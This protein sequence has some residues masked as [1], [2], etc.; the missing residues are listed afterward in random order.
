MA[1]AF[2]SAL[3]RFLAECAYVTN[4]HD[5]ATKWRIELKGGYFLD[6]FFNATVGKYSYTLSKGDARILGWDNAPH[7]SKLA[8]LPHHFHQADGSVVSSRLNGDPEHDLEIVRIE[9]EK[10]LRAR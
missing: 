9:I 4:V 10:F 8:N 3:S 2:E 7:H 5:L 6:I 1:I